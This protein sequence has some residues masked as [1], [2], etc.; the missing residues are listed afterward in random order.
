MSHRLLRLALLFLLVASSAAGAARGAGDARRAATVA[1]ER[2]SVVRFARR[3]VGVPY[4]YGGSSPATGFD[5]SGFTRFVYAHFGIDLPHF[6]G[7][8]FALGRRVASPAALRPGDLVFFDG[9]G[10]VGLYLGDGRF[11]H[12]PHSG[13]RVSIDPLSVEPEFDGARR[14]L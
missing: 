5:C 4:E 9:L 8:Q 14:V 12:A 2:D 13:A 6:S 7:T 1:R 3:F 11:I 10:H